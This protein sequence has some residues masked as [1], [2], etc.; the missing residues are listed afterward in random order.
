M[1][2]QRLGK[3]DRNPKIRTAEAFQYRI[4][5]ADDFA[6]AIEERP[7]R[8]ARGRLRVEDNLIGQNVADVPLRDQRPYEIALC[9][10]VEYLRNITAAFLQN[11]LGG[12]LIG[13]RQNRRES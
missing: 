12:V 5:D 13:A 4:R 9:E 2:Q 10:V 6:L 11:R 7:T 1:L 3:P 8:T